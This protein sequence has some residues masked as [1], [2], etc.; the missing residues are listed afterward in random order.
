MSERESRRRCYA[1]SGYS[2]IEVLIA[3]AILSVVML[4]I[5]TLFVM[6]RRNVYSGQQMSRANAV[7]TRVLEDLSYMTADEVRTNFSLT[8]ATAL[9]SPCLQAG[10]VTYNNC[11]VLRTSDATTPD[12]VTRWKELVQQPRFADGYVALVVT[13]TG[14][15]AGNVFTTAQFIRLNVVVGWSEMQ[16]NRVVAMSTAK[17]QR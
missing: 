10:G 13:P 8:D 12:Y 4:S 11:A 14:G 1:Q 5:L 6:A 3:M 9:T 17:P 16:R 15:T 7:A 2:L